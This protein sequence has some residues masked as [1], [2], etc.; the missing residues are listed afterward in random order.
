M[1]LTIEQIR[2]LCTERSFECGWEYLRQGR[3]V[4]L[5][6]NE[7]LITA[8]VLGT[9]QYHVEVRIH[10]QDVE[11]S[12][13]CAYDRGGC[14][15]HI[16]ATLLALRETDDELRTQEQ[17]REARLGITLE[18]LCLDELKEFILS[19]LKR[20]SYLR[21]RFMIRFSDKGSE[22]L[23]LDDYKREI[24]HLYFEMG[25][26]DGFIGRWNY[27]DFSPVFDLAR[28]Y[29]QKRNLKEAAT[30]YTALCEEIAGN[31][32]RVDDS[33]GHY[34]D[35]FMASLKGLVDCI[36][37]TKLTPG[38]RRAYVDYLFEKYMRGEPDYFRE[39]YDWALRE[40]CH[41]KNDLRYWQGLLRPHLPERLPEDTHSFQHCCAK[42][43]LMMQLHISSVL[44]DRDKVHSLFEK[45]YRRDYEFCRLYAEWLYENVDQERA[46]RVAEEGLTLFPAYLTRKLRRFLNRFYQHHSADK[47]KANLLVLFA[48]DGEWEDYGTLKE[49][50]SE[51]E[52]RTMIPKIVERLEREKRAPPSLFIQVY[53]REGMFADALER[54][55]AQKSLADLAAYHDDL[56]LR[57]P[58]RYFRAYR[59]LILP[60]ADSRTGR[61][62]YSDIVQYLK[63]M[64]EIPGYETET[65]KITE[66]LRQKYARKPAFQ[67][68]LRAL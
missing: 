46:I 45:Y 18:K 35:E 13:T 65:V 7:N 68:E 60:F 41:S 51:E 66:L 30:I 32:D 9:K 31:M 8:V 59:K 21:E 63:K 27:I 25:G 38:E 47:Q 5:E 29:E 36:S 4:K 52:W 26:F 56:A 2:T 61:G 43:L 34:A 28:H 57:Y 17:Q 12:C 50:C 11:A 58:D 55:L 62:H 23:S 64:K 53:L 24:A 19:E 15:K 20:D 1:K 54:V 3:V 14:C 6:R 48:L 39:H 16:V 33:D 40:M 44:K 37:E 10:R 22:P 49:L 67:D 42:D